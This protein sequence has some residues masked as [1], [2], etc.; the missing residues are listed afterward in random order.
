MTLYVV[1]TPIGNLADIT[2]RA[3]HILKEADGIVAE[4]TRQTQKLL[5]HY[6]IA[7]PLYSFF[8]P[9]EEEKLPALLQKLQSGQDLAL[10]TDA[11]T[12]SIADPGFRLVRA[13]VAAGIDVV[14]I[15]GA[16]AALCALTASGLPTDH[17]FFI[18]YLPEKPGKRSKAIVGL[19]KIP[20]TLVIY[21]SKWKGAKQAEEL[22]DILGDRSCCLARELTKIHEEF[23]R[24]TLAELAKR[25]RGEKLKGEMTLVVEGSSLRLASIVRKTPSPSR[26][27]C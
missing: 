26:G 11:G 15:P 7:K 27:T 19:K 18:G 25:L 12:P 14:P 4:D 20:H 2:L 16:C 8:E 13:C 1:A 23:W 6:N 9:K 5:Q 10:V 3:L 24:G 21:L 17:F 22:A